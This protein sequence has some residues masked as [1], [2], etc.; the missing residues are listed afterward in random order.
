[1]AK[2]DFFKAFMAC[3]Y[4]SKKKEEREMEEKCRAGE[5]LRF[6]EQE[7]K[8]QLSNMEKDIERR[9]AAANNLYEKIITESSFKTQVQDTMQMAR[10]LWMYSLAEFIT[11]DG[12]NSNDN[13]EDLLDELVEKLIV[14]SPVTGRK[15]LLNMQ[16]NAEYRNYIDGCLAGDRINPGFFWILLASMSGNEGEYTKDTSGFTREYCETVKKIDEYLNCRFPDSNLNK[17]VTHLV[18]DMLNK[19]L[20]FT[21]KEDMYGDY[22]MP[23]TI[24]PLV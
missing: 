6:K 16:T 2:K 21:S 4:F 23:S 7:R 13:P 5:E 11:S 9:I 22:Q 18:N 3:N 24:N 15:H 17:T 8:N 12:L 10:D 1:M 20:A 19:S 14:Y